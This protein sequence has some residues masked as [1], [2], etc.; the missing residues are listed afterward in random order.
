MR[1]Q[2]Y[3]SRLFA[4]AAALAWTPGL[5]L[6]LSRLDTAEAELESLVAEWQV[7]WG[8]K[9]S[10]ANAREL[11]VSLQA[12]GMVERQAGKPDEALGHLTTASDLLTTH[13]PDQL[14]DVREAQALTLQD[15]GRLVDSENLLREVL[16]SRQKSPADLKLAATFDHLALNLLYQGRYP[17]VAPLRDQA[18]A[19][20]A[21]EDLGFRARLAAHRGRL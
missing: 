19:A 12:L 10:P 5:A 17:E 20:T 6:D 9:P 11:A 15:L 14:A 1:F 7:V 4:A 3:F 21:A 8:Q 18:E 2:L 13:A 16:G